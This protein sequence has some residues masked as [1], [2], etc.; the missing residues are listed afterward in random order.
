MGCAGY[1]VK[2]ADC[3]DAVKF[4]CAFVS[5]QVVEAGAPT[6]AV[7]VGAVAGRYQRSFARQGMEAYVGDEYVHIE[8]AVVVSECETHPCAHLVN[9]HLA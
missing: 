8:V 2:D 4:A 7:S 6:V 3:S 9:A 5:Q 1:I